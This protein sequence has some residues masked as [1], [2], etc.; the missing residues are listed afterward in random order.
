V[1]RTD[2]AGTRDI[3]RA[4][5]AASAARAKRLQLRRS[6]LG[7]RPVREAPRRK[8]FAE[9]SSSQPI[10]APGGGFILE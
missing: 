9:P 1:A 10:R 3:K 4:N 2:S 7:A 6:G 5:A 8:T